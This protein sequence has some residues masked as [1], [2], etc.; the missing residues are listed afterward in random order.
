MTTDMGHANAATSMMA[1]TFSNVFDLRKTY[2]LVAGIAGIDPMQGTLGSPA[3]AKYLVDFGLQ[4]EIDS[5]EKPGDWP[6]GFI[7]IGATHPEDPPKFQYHTE[8]FE[9]NSKLADIAFTLSKDVPLADSPEAEATRAK[10]TFTPAN[11]PPQVLQCDTL[12]ADTW[13]AGNLIGERAQAWTKQLTHNKGTYCTT[14]Q[15]DNAT[16]AALIRA[17]R[18]GRADSNRVAVLRAGA[19]FDRPYAGQSVFESLSSFETAG[20]VPPAIENLYR[21]GLPLVTNINKNWQTWRDGVPERL[22]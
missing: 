13:W 21:A 18:A 17:A 16:Y 10:Y 11:R 9:L 2:F 19:D 3:W 5:R 14:Q 4:W 12:S 15:E 6:S 1:L 20:G 22:P 7:A 8:A